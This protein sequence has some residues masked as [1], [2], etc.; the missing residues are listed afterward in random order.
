MKVNETL[1]ALLF[2]HPA[3]FFSLGFGTGLSPIAP[4]TLCSFATLPLV[5]LLWTLSFWPAVAV[6]VGTAVFGIW[7]TG[8]TSQAMAVD[9]PGAIVWDE[10]VGMLITGLPFCTLTV[11]SY[12][13]AELGFFLAFV[14][15]IF[16]VFD[17]LKPFPI[18]WADQT[19]SGGLGIMLDDILAGVIA[20]LAFF[21]LLKFY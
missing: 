2:Q 8:I 7:C 14:F 10:V 1:A 13:P 11:K 3:H 4:G 15:V 19:F 5:W 20:G 12:S 16:R 6:I 9:D 18:S 21:L 17:I